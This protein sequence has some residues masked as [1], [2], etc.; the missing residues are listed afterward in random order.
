MLKG[1][2]SCLAQGMQH[3]LCPT[4]PRLVGSC[5]IYNQLP[6]SFNKTTSCK[7]WCRVL[8]LWR[9]LLTLHM[10][11]NGITQVLGQPAHSQHPLPL[12]MRRYFVLT[13]LGN[14]NASSTS[15][16]DILQVLGLG[17][18]SQCRHVHVFGTTVMADREE[19][20]AHRVFL[21]EQLVQRG[22]VLEGTWKFSEMEMHDNNSN[23]NSLWQE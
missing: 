22:W 23:S 9:I 19:Y 21:F 7:W 2:Q 14:L 13:T 3:L 18:Y 17:K 4:K 6:I 16:R 12:R 5:K 15:L 8:Q 11:V 10:C 20:R 1:C